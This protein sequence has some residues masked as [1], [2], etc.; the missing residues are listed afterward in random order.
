[1]LIRSAIVLSVVFLA[2]CGGG[3]SSG[4]SVAGAASNSPIGGPCGGDGDCSSGLTCEKDDPG[5]QCVKKC[6]TSADCGSGAVC[7]DEK[8][9]YAACKTKDDC[10]KGYSCQGKAPDLFCDAEEEPKK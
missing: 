4:K 7:N 8:K 1:M 3:E 10:R 9:C 6:A 5:G 2:A